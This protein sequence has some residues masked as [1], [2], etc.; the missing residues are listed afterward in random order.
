MRVVS[1]SMAEKKNEATGPESMETVVPPASDERPS[2][3]EIPVERPTVV[4]PFDVDAFARQT[5]TSPPAPFAPGAEVDP[6]RSL[7]TLS[8]EVELEYAR[9]RSLAAP[10]SPPDA[11]SL[12]DAR[13]ATPA[14][15]EV[16]RSAPPSS[17]PIEL[18]VEDDDDAPELQVV[19]SSIP[20]ALQDPNA[21]MKD[22]FQLGD[23][24]GALTLAESLLLR[25]PSNV[26]AQRLAEECQR[27]LVNMYAAKLGPLDRVPTLMVQPQELR[28]LSLDHRAGF[29]LSLVDGTSTLEMILDVGGMPLLDTLRILNDLYQQRIIA[30]RGQ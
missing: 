7:P 2:A 19:D 20:Q 8:N 3:G 30:F 25:D 18:E 1:E 29:L 4:P 16:Q 14:P 27:I 15:G 23:Y 21:E 28:W 17:G 13:F 11:L 5:I 9:L 24:S 12:A 6:R 26:A 10:S 22:R